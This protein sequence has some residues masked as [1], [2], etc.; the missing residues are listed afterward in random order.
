MDCFRSY[1]WKGNIRELSNVL[2]RAILMTDG[3]TI[4]VANLPENF[5]H[6]GNIKMTEC[7]IDSEKI[8]FDKAMELYEHNIIKK[9]YHVYK[10]SRKMAEYVQISQ[11]KANRLIQ[12]H[13]KHPHHT[14]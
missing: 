14:K 4:E 5:F 7:A 6:V 2:E 12:K 11:T 8:A 3:S 1:P 10:S 13:V 9:A